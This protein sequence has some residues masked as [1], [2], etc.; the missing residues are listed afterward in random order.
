METQGRIEEVKTGETSTGKQNYRVKIDG[1]WYSGFRD[2]DA[3]VAKGDVVNLAYEVNGQWRNIKNV[4]KLAGVETQ[5]VI[6]SAAKAAGFSQT[7]D[8]SIIRQ[9][10]V[11]ASAE[12]LAALLSDTEPQ[13]LTA[14]AA[15]EWCC[16]Y[17]LA[18]EEK[19]FK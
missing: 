13:A 10:L 8:E 7:R 11:K 2:G 5:K 15:A 17:T 14:Q 1:Q 19:L 6:D 12:V 3:P 9:C 16:A 18:V 4:E